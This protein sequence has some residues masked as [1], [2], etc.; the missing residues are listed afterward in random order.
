MIKLYDYGLSV[1]CYKQRLMMSILD[2]PY[3]S[4]PIDVL[5]TCAKDGAGVDKLAT[6]LRDKVSVFYGPSGGG[7]SM[8]APTCKAASS[9]RDTSARLGSITEMR[10]AIAGIPAMPSCVKSARKSAADPGG[11]SCKRKSGVWRG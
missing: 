10:P 9:A 1:N 5:L 2:V 6:T 11:P 8:T 7:K 4:I 3:E